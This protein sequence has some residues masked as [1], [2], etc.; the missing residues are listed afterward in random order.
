MARA[1]ITQA[2][3]P[4]EFETRVGLCFKLWVCVSA[5]RKRGG[6]DVRVRIAQRKVAKREFREE[7]RSLGDTSTRHPITTHHSN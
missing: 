3:H 1:G 4:I 5:S 6:F 2:R 7:L